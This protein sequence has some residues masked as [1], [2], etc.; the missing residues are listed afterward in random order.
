MTAIGQQWHQL[1]MFQT[2]RELRSSGMTFG[3]MPDTFEIGD[4]AE[5]ANEKLR[6]KKISQSRWP[7]SAGRT[8][9]DS[10]HDSIE[11]EGVKEPLHV[12]HYGDRGSMLLNGHHRFF[13]QEEHDPD[14][15]MPVSHGDFEMNHKPFRRTWASR[16]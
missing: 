1:P 14:R 11:R 6:V 4:T 15:L 2:P 12:E 3:D 9:A 16:D 5:S 13:S 10:L 7:G 8:S